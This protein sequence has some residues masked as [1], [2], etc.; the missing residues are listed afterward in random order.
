MLVSGVMDN[1]KE[2]NSFATSQ[3]LR[4]YAASPLT[5]NSLNRHNSYKETKSTADL[6]KF[7]NN[8]LVYLYTSPTKI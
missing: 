4:D 3:T 8:R 5:A 6:C 1:T 7:F 2:N